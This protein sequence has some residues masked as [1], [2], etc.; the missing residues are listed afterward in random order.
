M[1]LG[2]GGAH[3]LLSPCMSLGGCLQ[4]SRGN[5][6]GFHPGAAECDPTLSLSLARTALRPEHGQPRINQRQGQ[7]HSPQQTL[8]HTCTQ[9]HPPP[10]SHTHTRAAGRVDPWPF[11]P[12]RG[13]IKCLVHA[14]CSHVTLTDSR[15]NDL[16]EGLFNC[17]RWMASIGVLSLL[18]NQA[19]CHFKQ[20]YP[21]AAVQAHT[22][23][24][25]RGPPLPV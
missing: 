25:L 12:H 14:C 10:C 15:M 13:S 18:M 5:P 1:V 11:P 17:Q 6:V 21:H 7:C 4:L 20:I 2:G 9:N 24:G 8:W 16:F 22:L 3:I 19:I 23:R